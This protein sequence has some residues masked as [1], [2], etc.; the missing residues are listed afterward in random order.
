MNWPKKNVLVTGGAS[1]IG[2]HLVDALVKRQAKVR[3]V[4][5]LSSGKIKN[6][7]GHLKSGKVKFIKADLKE[8]KAAKEA[9]KGIDIVFHLAAD[10]GGRGYVDLHQAACASNL[11]L[12]GLIF[13]ACRQQRIEKVVYASS[14]CVYPNYLQTNPKKIL[15][16]TEKMV[17]PPYEADNMYGWAKLMA[18]MTLKAYY[19]DYGMKSASCRYFT[20]YGERGVENH[21]VIAMIARA[22]I[23][24][25]PF[26]VWG[27]GKQIRNWTYVGDIVEGTI[28]AAEKISDATAINLGTRERTSVISAV[29]EVLRYTGH[30]ARI[31]LQPSMPTGPYNRVADNALAKKLLGWEPQMKFMDGLHRTIDWYF[32]VKDS[33]QV[34]MILKRMLTER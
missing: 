6:I 34:K 19:K 20:V 8:S 1:F 28:L 14:G 22:F 10:H 30:K 11:M 3:V 9:V 31:I 15:Y 13:D 32:S 17:G 25:D 29:K 5:N 16:L 12:D 7:D 33:K 24:Q 4:D 18:E 26:F 2:S 21:A 27:T 23:K